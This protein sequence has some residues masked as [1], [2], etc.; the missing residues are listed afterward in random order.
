MADTIWYEVSPEEAYFEA[1]LQLAQLK[2]VQRESSS[3]DP[4][5]MDQGYDERVINV[6]NSQIRAQQREKRIKEKTISALKIIVLTL[7]VA[8]LFV[9]VAFALSDSFRESVYRLFANDYPTHTSL[10]VDHHEVDDENPA[11]VHTMPM[12][13]LSWFP[14]GVYTVE[15]EMYNPQSC[16]IA[17]A[18]DAG[19]HLYLDVFSMYLSTNINTEEMTRSETVIQGRSFIIYEGN[20]EVVVVWQD[21][22]AYFVLDAEGLTVNETLLAA[23]SVEQY[24]DE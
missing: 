16:S 4:W 5:D 7:A 19:V 6:M 18:S 8:N 12:Y 3:V 2:L 9:S 13:R 23:L 24:S 15:E 17:Y 22:Q 1:A 11:S 21:D 10:D 14:E 20:G